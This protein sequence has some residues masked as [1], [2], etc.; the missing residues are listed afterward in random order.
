M[1]VAV[2]LP[3]FQEFVREIGG[4]N[5]EVLS[6]VPPGSNPHTYELT[7]EDVARI[8]EADFFFLNG[9]GLDDR[10]VEIIEENRSEEAKVIPFSPNIRSPRGAELGNPDITAEQAGDNMHLWLDPA[11]AKV[12]AEIVADTFIIYD[13]VNE[14]FYSSNFGAYADRV[15]ELNREIAG[16]VGAIPADRRLLVTYHDS[17]EHLARAYALEVVGTVVADTAGVPA[18][19]DPAQLAQV[20]RDQRVPAVFAEYGF[21]DTVISQ[22]ASEAGVELCT[23]YSDILGDVDQSYADMMRANAEELSRCL[24][25]QG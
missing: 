15:A 6:L 13:S 22:A 16:K 8:K 1:T 10:F 12:Y 18:D 17:F 9:L 23:L 3:L 11:L 7:P 21:D 5:V 24:G 2:T 4:E 20:V 19:G 14:G 25:G